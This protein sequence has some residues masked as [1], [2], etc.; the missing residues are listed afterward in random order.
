MMNF[1]EHY[2]LV[3]KYLILQLSDKNPR[4]IDIITNGFNLFF[5]FFSGICFEIFF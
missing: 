1:E 5:V 4:T 3:L 2:I